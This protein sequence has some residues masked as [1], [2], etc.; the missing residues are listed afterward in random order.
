[1]NTKQAKQSKVAN[2][3]EIAEQAERG[4]DVSKHF[5]NQYAAKQRVNIDFPLNLLRAIDAECQR[6]GVT[7]Q[8][9]IKMVCDER[10]RQ[11]HMI[12]ANSVQ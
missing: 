5:T 4:E 10:L 9:W 8:A 12:Y 3:D 7:R 2:I 1:M 6:I 11:V